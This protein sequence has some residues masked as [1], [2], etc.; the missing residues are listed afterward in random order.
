M[1]NGMVIDVPLELAPEYLKKFVSWLPLK[2]D[3]DLIDLLSAM[4]GKTHTVVPFSK[5]AIRELDL[6]RTQFY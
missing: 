5:L 3:S 2:D 1:P 6:L 4:M